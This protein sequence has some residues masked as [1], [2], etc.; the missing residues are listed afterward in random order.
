VEPSGEILGE[1]PTLCVIWQPAEREDGTGL[2]RDD[3]RT[4]PRTPDLDESRIL[5]R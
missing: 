1:L 2:G 5:P 4:E 3:V